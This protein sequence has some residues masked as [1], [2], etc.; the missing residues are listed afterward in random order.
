MDPVKMYFLF[1]MGIFHCY[2][3]LPKGTFSIHF[4]QKKPSRHR[5]HRIISPFEPGAFRSR[6]TFSSFPS[7]VGS[8]IWTLFAPFCARAQGVSKGTYGWLI[9]WNYTSSRLLWKPESFKENTLPALPSTKPQQKNIKE[10][11]IL[12]PSDFFFLVISCNRDWTR[13]HLLYVSSLRAPW[14]WSSMRRFEVHA[15]LA[16]DPCCLR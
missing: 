2:V 11:P 7:S 12:E 13:N 5:N 8:K 9:C 14:W 10:L 15:P 16:N 6:S 3:S 4:L 1:E